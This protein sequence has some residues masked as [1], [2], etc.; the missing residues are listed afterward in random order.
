M[1]LSNVFTFCAS[2]L[3]SDELP[4]DLA[5]YHSSKVHD[6][7]D[8]DLDNLVSILPAAL[9]ILFIQ[10]LER[11]TK[12]FESE[13]AKRFFNQFINCL[14]SNSNSEISNNLAKLKKDLIN[15]L[16]IT[17]DDLCK[18]KKI[19][20]P[21][22]ISFYKEQMELAVLISVVEINHFLYDNSNSKE[23]SYFIRA[24]ANY[25]NEE[26]SNLTK[27]IVKVTKKI[28]LYELGVFKAMIKSYLEKLDEKSDEK[29]GIKSLLDFIGDILKINEEQSWYSFSFIKLEAKEKQVVKFVFDYLICNIDDL[30][31]LLNFSCKVF[32]TRSNIGSKEVEQG[33]NNYQIIINDF[34]NTKPDGK[35]TTFTDFFVALV[36]RIKKQRKDESEKDQPAKKAEK[37]VEILCEVACSKVKR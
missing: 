3:F 14:K 6:P 5:A 33:I 35:K 8:D 21:Q 1:F 34:A 31:S 22:E 9:P 26:E 37:I 27:L 19:F 15:E 18:N 28:A 30:I 17:Q 24:F 10:V 23:L 2:Q 13:K 20:S 11:Y 4:G 36:E 12:C 7:K 25:C 16:P 32:H 29:G